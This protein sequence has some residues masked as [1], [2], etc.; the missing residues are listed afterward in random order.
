MDKH[1]TLLNINFTQRAIDSYVDATQ[2]CQSRKKPFANWFRTKNTK[3]FLKQF[4][5]PIRKTNR[6]SWINT[7]CLEHLLDWVLR[8]EYDL[9]LLNN[10]LA[11]PFENKAKEIPPSTKVCS[12]CYEELSVS[13]FG[14]NKNMKDG[15]DRR[16]KTCYKVERTRDSAKHTTRSLEYYHENKE[17]CNSKKKEWAQKNKDKVN[18]ANK[19]FYEKKQAQKQEEE[20]KEAENL[21]NT[22]KNLGQIV[23]SGKNDEPYQV[24]CRE[25][26][27]YVDVTN[28]CKAGGK[29]FAKWH[30]LKRTGK[31]LSIL[32]NHIKEGDE[33]DLEKVNSSV[34]R[35]VPTKLIDIHQ[36]GNAKAQ[37][38]W[39][40]PKVAINIAQWISPE[41]DVQVSAWVHQ[42]LDDTVELKN[43][44]LNLANKLQL[45]N[46]YQQSELEIKGYNVKSRESDGYINITNL[47]KA[48]KRV[49]STWMRSKKSQQFL[50]VLSSVVQICTTKLI[51]IHQAGDAKAQ[52]TWVH[53]R[54]AINIAQWISPEFDVQVSEWV[55]QLLVLGQVRLTDEVSDKEVIGVQTSKLK[56]NRLVSE[57]KDEEA[58]VV[59]ELISEKMKT[60]ERKNLLLLQENDRLSKYL[61][62]RRRVQYDKKKVIYVVKHDEFENCYKVG[63]AN[64]LTSRM[65]TYNTGAPENYKVVYYQYTMYN[66]TVELMIRKKFLESLYCHN[67][68]WFQLDEGPEIL[69]DNIKKAIAFF[70]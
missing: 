63:I 32:N 6:H 47:C 4:P 54:V 8:S 23:L 34:G 14:C 9:E 58:L 37:G 42:L 40:H 41:F 18:A 55:H 50:S 19:R 16:C 60:L 13:N 7:E 36:A 53:P 33:I 48:G 11:E 43:K 38:T 51:D 39:V 69:I 61:E 65:S 44:V 2:I 22:I 17:A 49:F 64:H 45:Q 5:D 66:A 29:E 12:K 62:K 3:M 30:R 70:D 59:A 25:S 26:D 35:K 67:K 27:G 46:K 28:L 1:F 52:G 31:F 57:G 21:T 10:K 24:V 68:E 20:N 15:Y 56:H